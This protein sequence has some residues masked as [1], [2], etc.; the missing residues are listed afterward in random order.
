LGEA[1]VMR[2]WESVSEEAAEAS[3]TKTKAPNS[4]ILATK[5]GDARLTMSE[6]QCRAL[7]G[8]TM[9]LILALRRA[10]AAGGVVTGAGTAG[11]AAAGTR[12]RERDSALVVGLNK[13]THTLESA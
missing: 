7:A 10:A 5:A 1:E 2:Y 9:A 6:G 4:V 3:K 12:S 13:L 11:T 8:D